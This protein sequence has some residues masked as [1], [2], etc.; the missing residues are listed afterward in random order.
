MTEGRA[1]V[2]IFAA[3]LVVF[4]GA[5]GLLASFT[6]DGTAFALAM[7]LIGGAGAHACSLVVIHYSDK[8]QSQRPR[9]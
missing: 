4:I 2:L 6:T 3:T 9:R 8:S 5:C 7:I 1:I